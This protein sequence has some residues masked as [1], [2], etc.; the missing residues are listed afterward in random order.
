MKQIAMVSMRPC[1][2]GGPGTTIPDQPNQSFRGGMLSGLQF[3]QNQ[4]L[5]GYGLR[6]RGLRRRGLLPRSYFLQLEL[7]TTLSL[8]NAGHACMDLDVSQKIALDGC[9]CGRTEEI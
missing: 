6:R 4:L 1:K 8:I 5:D 9:E 3:I 7:E 2:V